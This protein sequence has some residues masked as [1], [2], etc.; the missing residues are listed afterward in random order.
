MGGG[1]GNATHNTAV[2]L[3]RCGHV[4]HVLTARLP[5]QP[6]VE[7]L[8]GVVVH[9]VSSFRRSIMECGLIGAASYLLFAL[10][11]LIRLGR[12]HRY[13]VYQ[14]Y[15]GMPTGL[16][17][18]YVHFVLKK[19]YVL[20][21]RGSDVPG[22]DHSNWYMAPLHRL[23]MP[24]TRYLW[25]RAAKVTVLSR[26]L[27]ALARS[28][29]P[30]VETVVISNA[31]DPDVFPA[32]PTAT[33]AAQPGAPLRLLTVCRMVR[34]KGLNFLIEAMQELRKD[35]I[36]LD[37][38]GSGQEWQSVAQ[39]IEKRGLEDCVTMLGYVPRD[40][41]YHYY[42]QADIFVLPSLSESF[43]QVLLEA[44]SCGLPIV[45]TTVGG[46]PE[47]IRPERNGVLIPPADPRAIVDAVRH[48]A[49]QPALRDEI[50]R[51][52]AAHVRNRY[53]WAAVAGQYET[54]YQRAL[55]G[56]LDEP[57]TII[58]PRWAERGKSR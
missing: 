32:K 46:I 34:R 13:D 18:L 21:L 58:E 33:S 17:A 31:I 37:L 54:L 25:K 24:L 49:A 35:G 55:S 28:T 29:C 40:Q 9:R 38:I 4:V 53:S 47:T 50:G 27:D 42:H 7:T 20:A 14:L 1:A 48:L 10:A 44:M 26:G 23:L 2:G 36:E 11:A 45:A 52:N 30:D 51:R 5:G 15:F 16:L 3:A 41:L 22:Y 8:D 19:P 6:A 39:L 56:E 57:A 43:G 12:E